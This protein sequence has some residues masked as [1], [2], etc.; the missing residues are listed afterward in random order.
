MIEQSCYL[1]ISDRK[2][3]INYIKSEVLEAFVS[4][5]QIIDR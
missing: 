3:R 2:S 5:N 4:H 1:R